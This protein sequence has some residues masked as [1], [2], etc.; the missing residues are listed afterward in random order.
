MKIHVF[1]P[2]VV[3]KQAINCCLKMIGNGYLSGLVERG[4]ARRKRESIIRRATKKKRPPP[5]KGDN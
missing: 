3:N 1:T 2:L 4:Q 5:T